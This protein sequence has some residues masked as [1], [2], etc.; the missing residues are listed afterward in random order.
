MTTT[1]SIPL[2]YRERLLIF[3]ALQFKLNT[4]R[5]AGVNVELFEKDQIALMKKVYATLEDNPPTVV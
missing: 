4:A 3:Q 1:I 2:S 5:D